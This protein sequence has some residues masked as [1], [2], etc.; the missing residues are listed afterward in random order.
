M[1]DHPNNNA[2]IEFM[3]SSLEKN[4]NLLE[5]EGEAVVDPTAR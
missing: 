1:V 4:L 5:E 2:D 3:L